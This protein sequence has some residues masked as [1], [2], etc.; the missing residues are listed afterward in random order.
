[1][2]LAALTHSLV[3]MSTR[4]GLTR[5]RVIDYASLLSGQIGRVIFS[6]A[7]FVLLARALSLG[8]FGVFA[9]CSAMG[10]VLSRLSGLGFVSPLFRVATVRPRL[11]GIYT[12]GF[13]L[14]TLFTLPF[15]VGIALTVHYLL[16]SD[17][18]SVQAFLAII[19]TEVL[20]WRGVEAVIIV[21]N[22]LGRYALGSSIAIAGVAVKALAAGIF[23]Y[24]DVKML[25]HWALYY[26]VAL[27]TVL[28][29]SVVFFYPKQRL[30]WKPRAWA[31]RLRDALGVSAAEALFYTQSE[32]DKVLVLALGGEVLAGLYAIVMRLI[33][34]TAI[35]LRALSTMLTKW[36]MRA[37]Q[38]GNSSSTGLKL[39]VAIGATSIA[40]LVG[41][42]VILS[43]VPDILGKSIA[44]GTSYL[45]LMLLVPAFRNAI[46]LHTELL[47]GHERM[48]ER[49]VLLI[50][51]TA[52]KAGLI[53]ILLALLNDFNAIAL[54]L[55]ALYAALYIVSA[56]VTYVSVLGNPPKAVQAAS[57]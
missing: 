40:G 26:V 4:A 10:I 34:L 24:L 32:L 44:T 52:V 54:W 21:N 29:V 33:D 39:D 35:P 6:M 22:G 31:G 56:L 42:Y 46:E 48:K 37:R 2:P 43:F 28:V 16:Y 9:S 1:M 5:Q 41:M 15:L 53:S 11:I 18:I 49:V 55:N 25:E 23:W 7:Y 27:G 20:L 38:G 8:E 57:K 36:I 19:L 3:N 30:R 12:G 17:L 50:Y 14:A 45:L 13:L 51:L 47:Y